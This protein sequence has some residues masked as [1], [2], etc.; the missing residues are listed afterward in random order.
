MSPPSPDV[1]ANDTDGEERVRTVASALSK[2]RSAVWVAEQSDVT[3][4]TAQKYLEKG[5]EDGRL[6][7]IEHDRTTLYVP[8]PREQYLDEIATLVD[9]HS[10]D[11]L[12]RELSAMSERIESWQE[13]YDVM[14]PDALRTTIDESLTVD[15]RRERERV[16][17]DWTYVQEMRTL[18]RHA[19]RLYD[20]LARVQRSSASSIA[21]A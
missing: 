14:E 9:E 10:K 2:P 21:D 8:D 1:W 6:E 13:R 17:E 5:V 15:E 19:I 16:V 7:T 3:Y 18:V 11:E 12:T 20:D 4:K